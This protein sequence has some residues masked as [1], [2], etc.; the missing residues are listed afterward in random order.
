MRHLRVGSQRPG[1]HGAGRSRLRGVGEAE[2]HPGSCLAAGAGAARGTCCGEGTSP[3]G[4]ES[5]AGFILCGLWRNALGGL[6]LAVSSPAVS[7]LPCKPEAAGVEA[8]GTADPGYTR[9]PPLF[10]FRKP[11]PLCTQNQPCQQGCGQLAGRSPDAELL[12]AQETC[13]GV[14]GQRHPYSLPI[15][16]SPPPV[17]EF[18]AVH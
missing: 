9:L 2:W 15:P 5:L 12:S 6:L 14:V 1:S 16:V 13:G 11:V 8:P 4:G 3:Y 18:M 17:L 10:F 7:Q